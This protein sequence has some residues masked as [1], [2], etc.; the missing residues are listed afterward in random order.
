VGFLV[1]LSFF[2]IDLRGKG[3]LTYSNISNVISDSTVT[4]VLAIGN[5]FVISTAEIDLSFAN[6][7]PLAGVV[8]AMLVP[9][10]GIIPALLAAL[11]VG[12]FVGLV[13]GTIVVLVGVPSFIVTLGM[14]SILDGFDQDIS[15]QQSLPVTNSLFDNIFGSGQLGSVPV[16]VFWTVGVGLLAAWVLQRTT[17][18][19]QTQA[20]GGNVL[21]AR[22]SGIQTDKIRISVFVIN[23]LLAALGGL[24]YVGQYHGA[25]YQYG[26]SGELILALSAVIIGGTALT[27]GKGTILGAIIGSLLLGFITNGL[28]L[29]GLSAQSQ[30]MLEGIIIVVAVTISGRKWLSAA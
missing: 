29:M 12:A 21:A 19:R 20:T 16:L 15:N 25:S 2:A 23:G 30:E 9:H 1:V 7:A 6:V 5:V 17:F 27:G 11:A 18:G 24:L 14:L 4:S 10:V 28:I 8:L 13:N 22:F 3:F 26:G